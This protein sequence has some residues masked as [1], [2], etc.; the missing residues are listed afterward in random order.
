VKWISFSQE[1]TV[2][3]PY[4]IHLLCKLG[5]CAGEYVSDIKMIK[6]ISQI[7]SQ[8]FDDM[9]IVFF[10]SGYI[11]RKK[12]ITNFCEEYTD[13]NSNY[14]DTITYN[15][16]DYIFKKGG[17]V[18]ISFRLGLLNLDPSFYEII[19]LLFKQFHNNL[20]FVSGKSKRAFYFIG[21]QGNDKLIFVDPHYNQQLTNNFDKDYE[22]YYTDNY[23]LM[24]IK[25]LSSELTLGIGIFNSLHFTQFLD[26][27]IWFNNNTR[28]HHLI[29]IDKE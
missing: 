16:V 26:D 11:S 22:S 6:I 8:I 5:K 25:D 18:F 21:I 10:E 23:Y 3:P 12:L 13:F 28:E 14:L 29:I 1:A 17:I 24:D 15:G 20:G 4:S 9:N 19:P 27:L 7:N 2:I